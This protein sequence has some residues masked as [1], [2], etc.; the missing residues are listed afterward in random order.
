MTQEN[1][2]PGTTYLGCSRCRVAI[3]PKE[4]TV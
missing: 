2:M 1:H 4:R 3:D